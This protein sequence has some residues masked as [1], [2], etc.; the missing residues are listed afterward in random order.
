MGI[1]CTALNPT[2]D[3]STDAHDRV[4]DVFGKFI[5]KGI[6]RLLSSLAAAKP[7]KSGT[8]L[9]CRASLSSPRTGKKRHIFAPTCRFNLMGLG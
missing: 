9:M 8:V 5:T 3:K 7:R 6:S 4:I 1:I 2:R